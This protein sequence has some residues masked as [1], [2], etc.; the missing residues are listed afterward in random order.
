MNKIISNKSTQTKRFFYFFYYIFLI[1][2]TKK[3]QIVLSIYNLNHY[4]KIHLIIQGS[5]NQNLLST[6]FSNE[7][8]EVYV[9]G[10]KNDSCKKECNLLE[11]KNNITL[12]YNNKIQ[13]CEKMFSNLINLIEIDLSDF[14]FSQVTSINQ[15]FIDCA[16]LTKINFGRITTPSLKNMESAFSHCYKLTSIDISNFDTSQVSNMHGLFNDCSNLEKINFGKI[17]TSSVKNMRSLFN[18]CKKLISLDL[19]NFDT[20]KVINMDKMFYFCQNLKFLNLS[21]FNTQNVDSIYKMFHHCQS[22]IYLNLYSFKLKNTVDRTNAT[23]GISSFV[24]YCIIDSNT[25]NYILGN[26]KT[27]NCEDD[28]FK[29]NIKIDIIN[30]KCV[31]SCIN[32]EYEKENICYNECPFG[33]YKLFCEGNECENDIIQCFNITPEG[34]YLDTNINKFKKCFNTCKYCYEPGNETYNNCIE[35]I[36]NFTFLN[37]SQYKTNCFQECQFYYYFNNENNYICSSN[38]IS[39]YNKIILEKR[40]CIGDCKLD[41][42]YKYE[43]NNFCYNSCPNG[44]Y[45]IEDA[46]SKLAMILFLMVIILILLLI[47]IN[48]A[49]KIAENVTQAETKIIIIV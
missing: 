40:K 17:K 44:T 19:S 49:I 32:N 47:I 36:S 27:S 9:N 22:L 30:N 8:S 2:L 34:Y 28:C 14:D 43:Y 15:M 20:S 45:E 24:K 6:N 29:E 26:D 33:S 42:T 3:M 13:S 37:E 12:G 11:D 48:N 16:N 10:V 4:S 38:C 7:P 23:I 35:F 21:N 39:F 41:D 1:I 25:K 18:S 5:G 31:K 46:N